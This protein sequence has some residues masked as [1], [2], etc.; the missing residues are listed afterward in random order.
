MNDTIELALPCRLISMDVE[1]APAD[2]ASSLE[3]LVAKAVLLR[4]NTVQ[5]LS[6]FFHLPVRLVSDVATSMWEKGLL[7]V[8]LESNHLD[9]SEEARSALTD[10]GEL[11]RRQRVSPE[12]FVFEPLT[13]RVLADEDRGVSH[14]SWHNTLRVPFQGDIGPEDVPEEQLVRAVQ[15]LLDRRRKSGIY[16]HVSRVGFGNRLLRPPGQVRWFHVKAGVTQ[17]VQSGLLDLVINDDGWDAESKHRLTAHVQNLVAEAPESEFARRLSAHADQQLKAPETLES[18]LTNLSDLVSR[19]D[20]VPSTSARQQHSHLTSLLRRI[21]QQTDQRE[22]T[23]ADATMVSNRAGHDWAVSNLIEESHR[24]LVLVVPEL[25]YRELNPLLDALREATIA[26]GV[27]LVVLWGRSPGEELSENVAAALVTDLR[28]AGAEILLAQDSCETDACLVIQDDERALVTSV[29]ALGGH[30]S[31]DRIGV[32][33]GAPGDSDRP[34]QAVVELLAWCRKAFPDWREQRKIAVHADDFDRPALVA[35][36][37]RQPGDDVGAPPDNPDEAEL[38]LWKTS[39]QWLHMGVQ[40]QQQRLQG[41][42]SVRIRVDADNRDLVWNL[43]K[44]A[45]RRLVVGDDRIDSSV[46]DTN[47]TTAL[48]QSR[49]L[50][51][52]VQVLCPRPSGAAQDHPFLAIEQGDARVPIRFTGAAAR[53][54]VSDASLLIGSLS[55]LADSEGRFRP[56]GQ[57]R[58]QIGVQ[59]DS[60]EVAVEVA[61]L[62]KAVPA[63]RPLKLPTILPP[64]LEDP[65]ALEMP[66]LREV[67]QAATGRH[68]AELVTARLAVVERPWTVLDN[69]RKAGV[70]GD[71]L[72]SAVAGAVQAGFQ[73]G[74]GREDCLAWLVG[75]AWE[76][77][78][79]VEGALIAPLL[80]P[81]HASFARAA[82]AASALEIGPLG[83]YLEE[84]VLELLEE[85]TDDRDVAVVAAGTFAEALLR[86][87]AGGRDTT[88]F[89]LPRLP[90][91]WRGFAETFVAGYSAGEGSLPLAT[92]LNEQ[93]RRDLL[94]EIENGRRRL[95]DLVER[96]AQLRNRF[97][98]PAGRVLYRE[99]F[100]PHGLLTT[101]LAAAKTGADQVAALSPT[102]PG[103]VQRY[104]DRIIE[105]VPD[106]PA[107]VWS[108]QL[109]WLRTVE[110][111]VGTCSRLAALIARRSNDGRAIILGTGQ[112]V[113]ARHM[114]GSWDQMFS[115]AD[116]LGWPWRH[117]LLALMDALEPVVL[118]A[119]G[120]V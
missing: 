74:A 22:R 92:V 83:D 105:R 27:R 69:W 17:D 56:R 52:A 75:D 41:R 117:P 70:A 66:L 79:F 67:R 60:E 24:Q 63:A 43:V 93:A 47:F 101:V 8:D 38:Q 2:G 11:A 42:K 71:V 14:T 54:V 20:S 87:N 18:L 7:V 96:L 109:G 37:T 40:Q 49:S 86:G 112:A 21:E 44:G 58:S 95:V 61:S 98:F 73:D 64:G 100:S 76:R 106:A 31:G 116:G 50:G 99:L 39:W 26:R 15:K 48:R 46:A 53:L 19:L 77:R 102:L 32:L 84:I 29:S 25:L 103:D 51:A 10:E 88:E 104:L 110:D 28:R 119:R 9:L 94:D 113:I 114:A 5:Q 35:R 59:I 78:S 62:L 34:A 33:I 6:E 80:G 16:E 111:V 68:V 89:L 90:A 65:Q 57:R 97:T 36:R 3:T 13:G 1:L 45:R 72:R 91:G 85:A 107:M 115:E 30:R 82:G 81:E 118:W 55:P 12:T 4:K 108:S 23:L 120:Q